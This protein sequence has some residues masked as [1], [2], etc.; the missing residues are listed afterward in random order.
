MSKDKLKII[1]ALLH[2][3]LML[4]VFIIG[5]SLLITELG[6]KVTIGVWLVSY[7]VFLGGKA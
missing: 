7:V 5:S 1:M 2:L 4:T 6:W 3:V